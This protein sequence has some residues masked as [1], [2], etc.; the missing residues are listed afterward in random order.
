MDYLVVAKDEAPTD[1]FK[2]IGV[3][4][5]VVHDQ[6]S[7]GRPC[8]PPRVIVELS[9]EAAAALTK[10]PIVRLVEPR[11]PMTKADIAAKINELYRSGSP[12]AEK[13]AD[14]LL[15]LMVHLD[16]TAKERA[17]ERG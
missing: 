8:N 6:W 14:A 13:A 17:N 3:P 10:N 9:I 5:K 12:E 7:D 11:T 2:A 4:P 1:W 16:Q 15:D